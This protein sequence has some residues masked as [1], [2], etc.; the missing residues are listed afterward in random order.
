MSFVKVAMTKIC[1]Y[2]LW[3]VIIMLIN[4]MI[5]HH[6]CCWHYLC[7]YFAFL[8]VNFRRNTALPFVNFGS[9]GRNGRWRE[10]EIVIR[11]TQGNLSKRPEARDH[12][13]ECPGGKVISFSGLLEASNDLRGLVNPGQVSN[14]V[15]VF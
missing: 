10:A 2:L 3:I 6:C 9:L 1:L 8:F 12:S 7:F 5:L 13:E 14:K 15:I 11:P 4:F